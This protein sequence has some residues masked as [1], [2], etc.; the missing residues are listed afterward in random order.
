M[1]GITIFWFKRDLRLQDN[2]ALSAAIAYGKPLLLV[3]LMEPSI[4]A[5]PHYDERHLRFVKESLRDLQEE[6]GP[7]DLH[8]SAV[9]IE[10]LPFFESIFQEFQVEK[11]FSTRETGL[12]ITFARD[13]EIADFLKQSGVVW[14]EFQANGVLRGKQDRSDWRKSWYAYMN[15]PI[16]DP[17]LQNATSLPLEKLPEIIQSDILDLDTPETEFQRG[18][19]QEGR[20]WMES[21]FDHRIA[22]YAAYISKPELSR[23]GCSRLSPYFA[24]GNLSIR[25]VFQRAKEFK[26]SSRYKREANAFMSRLR[27]QSHFIQK[28]EMEPRMEFE[29]INRAF[30]SLEQPLNPVY[31][32]AWQE[33]KTGYPLVDA[34]V[35]CVVQTGYINFRMRAMITSFLTHHLF[36][37]FKTIGPWLARQ[38]LDFEPGIHYGQLQMQAGFTGTNTVRVYNPTRNAQ[39]HDP[40]ADFIKKYVPELRNLPSHLAITPWEITPLEEGYYEFQYGHDYPKRIVLTENTRKE[41]LQKLYGTRKQTLAKAEKQRILKKH[42][43]PGPRNA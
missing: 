18:G 33:G 12:E 25:E 4:W 42:T 9:Q 32:K 27:W 1:A 23:S 16:A 8:L 3:Y 30:L 31:I 15:A 28:F 7:Y 19:T 34:S 6:L 39:A 24:W 35:R 2:E 37:H 26:K 11:V 21:F 5:D 20:K 22:N 41:A 43:L 13:I 36:Q 29:A 17:N 38:F 40:D 14:E 10:A